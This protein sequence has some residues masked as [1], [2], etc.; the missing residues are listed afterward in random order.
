LRVRANRDFIS[1]Y[2]NNVNKGVMNGLTWPCFI[3]PALG[4]FS[5]LAGAQSA[6]ASLSFFDNAPA[7]RRL[8]KALPQCFPPSGHSRLEH[9]QPFIRRFAAFGVF[10]LSLGRI[11]AKA[12]QGY[13]VRQKITLL[14]L[15]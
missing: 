10:F 5:S 15:C 7:G 6:P 14:S 13:H 12:A 1:Y 2:L 8:C 9:S 3:P 11:R 4:G